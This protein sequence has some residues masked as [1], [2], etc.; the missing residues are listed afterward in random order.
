M[1]TE[2]IFLHVRPSDLRDPLTSQYLVALISDR[3]AWSSAAQILLH[4]Y[5][6][7]T[8]NEV[9]LDAFVQFFTELVN[10][11]PDGRKVLM[12]KNMLAGSNGLIIAFGKGEHSSTPFSSEFLLSQVPMIILTDIRSF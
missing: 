12:M 10:V 2:L 6:N 9:D 3:S 4:R 7:P 1:P 11:C 5:I 8:W